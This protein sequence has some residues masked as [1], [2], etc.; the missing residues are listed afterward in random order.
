MVLNGDVLT[1]SD[2][3]KLLDYHLEMGA[4]VTVAAVIYRVDIPFGVLRVDGNHV[5][6][7]EEKPSQSFLCNAGMYV[8]DPGA[9]DLVPADRSL[10]MTDVIEAALAA[11]QRVSVFPVHEYWTDIG[12][13]TDLQKAMARFKAVEST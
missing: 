3:G 11:G 4:F 5:I 6:G 1:A 8:L 10:D 9:I 12:S 13:P 2:F 7:L